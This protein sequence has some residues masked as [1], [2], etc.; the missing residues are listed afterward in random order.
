[1]SKCIKDKIYHARIWILQCTRERAQQF[2]AK[3]YADKDVIPDDVEAMTMSYKAAG[4]TEEYV[5]WFSSTPTVATISHE[6]LHVLLFVLRA[7]GVRVSADNSDAACY[8]LGWIVDEIC[9]HISWKV[10]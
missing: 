4:D 9:N 10:K 7:H 1:M 2:I 6:A 5:V 8:Y 3:K